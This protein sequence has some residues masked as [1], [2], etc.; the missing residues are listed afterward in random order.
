VGGWSH[1]GV[2][3]QTVLPSAIASGRLTPTA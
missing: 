3:G 1:L 2:V